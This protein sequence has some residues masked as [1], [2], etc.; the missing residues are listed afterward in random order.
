MST[1]HLLPIITRPTRITTHSSTLIDNIF[2]SA[3]PKTV[4]ASDISDHL[5]IQARFDM[6]TTKHLTHLRTDYGIISEDRKEPFSRSLSEL[7]WSPVLS[8]SANGDTNRAYDLF[9]GIY[10][11]AYNTALPLMQRKKISRSYYMYPWMTQGLLKA[12]KKKSLL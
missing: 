9:M 1:H 3:W 12:C 5:P 2:T 11:D 7:D 6:E 10:K 4:I 8:A